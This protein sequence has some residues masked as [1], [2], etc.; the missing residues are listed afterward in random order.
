MRKTSKEV[1]SLG[2]AAF[3]RDG[4]WEV[5]IDE[6]TSGAHKW[7]AQIESPSVYLYFTVQSPLVIDEML[8]FLT[9]QTT[10]K[11][12]LR[13]SDQNQNGQIVIGKNK[14]EPI[15]LVR[16]DEFSDRY[17]L[18]AE[19]KRGLIARVTIGGS[20]LN[21]FVNALRQAK[22]DLDEADVD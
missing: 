15:T 3:G 19:T 21:S 7:F 8:S 20:D 5:A 12:A 6:T 18:I 14:E 1:E 9:T 11:T 17:F 10:E 22:E 13:G 16:D 4:C 2:L